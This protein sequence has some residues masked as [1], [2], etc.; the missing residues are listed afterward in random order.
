[1]IGPRAVSVHLTFRQRGPRRIRILRA[2]G[3]GDLT[4]PSER[5]RHQRPGRSTDRAPHVYLNQYDSDDNW[6]A[7]YEG[8]AWEI[9]QAP[10][11][12]PTSSPPS[13]T[14]G[15]FAG[16]ATCELPAHR[17]VSV[18]RTLVSRARGMKL[19]C[20][21]A[22]R[23]L[24]PS[25]ADEHRSADRRR[26][27]RGEA[28]DPTGGR[29]GRR[30]IRAALAAW[31]SPGGF[32]RAFRH[33]LTIFPTA[34]E[35]RKRFWGNYRETRP[36]CPH[37]ENCAHDLRP[38]SAVPARMLR[39]ASGR[40]RSPRRA[41]ARS[42]W[43]SRARGQNRRRGGPRRA[44]LTADDTAPSAAGAGAMLDCSAIT[45][46]MSR[47]RRVTVSSAP[48]V[49]Y[50]FVSVRGARRTNQPTSRAGFSATTGT[51]SRSTSRPCGG[52]AGGTRDEVRP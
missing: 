20:R 28:A 30:L 37:P 22:T 42:G 14:S 26:V 17:C 11:A 10:A 40:Q 36:A 1:M 13:G 25:L 39:R 44:F 23:H 27:S 31:T 38:P 2:F 29:A 47:A 41:P 45:R 50:V 7:H 32:R 21:R 18:S 19:P 24:R 52:T 33:D 48:P 4:D 12:S 5:R 49:V 34:A 51:P 6:R 43:W 46:R 9:D 35:C 15:T 16:T 8:T 3:A